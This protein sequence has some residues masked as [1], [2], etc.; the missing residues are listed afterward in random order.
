MHYLKSTK[1]DILT[2]KTDV[3]RV[4]KWHGDA[5]FTVHNDFRSHTVG[6]MTLGSFQTILTKQEVNTKSSM[7]A[8]LAS[9]DD[10]VS[11][12]EW[13][14]VFLETQGYEIRE[15]LVYCDNPSWNKW[16]VEFFK[17]NWTF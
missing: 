3:T 1:D 6:V 8:E 14:K 9:I 15:N 5:L 7:E 12:I 10:V 16:Q 11:K 2:L 4:M 13:T 17:K